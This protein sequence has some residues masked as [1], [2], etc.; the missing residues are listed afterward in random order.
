MVGWASATLDTITKGNSCLFGSSSVF[1]PL[2]S[3]I[4][5][6]C[7]CPWTRLCCLWLSNTAALS[8]YVG[9]REEG[10]WFWRL[11]IQ[12]SG[13]GYIDI[14]W[15][16]FKTLEAHGISDDM[17]YLCVQHTWR[18]MTFFYFPSSAAAARPAGFCSP[19]GRWINQEC[20]SAY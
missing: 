16:F 10:G 1:P 5:S 2:F 9:G 3:A 20:L 12:R 14:C 18:K 11:I 17:A 6:S 8:T 7:C 4:P 19:K 15:A 13:A